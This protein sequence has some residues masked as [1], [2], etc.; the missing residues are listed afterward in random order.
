MASLVYTSGVAEF[1]R[2]NHDWL[3]GNAVAILVTSGYT[4]D[5]DHDFISDLT[6]GSNELSGTGY[7]RKVLGTKTVTNDDTNDRAALDAADVTWTGINTAGDAAAVVIAID[8]GNDATSPLLAYID[9]GGF[10]IVT[11]GGDVTIQWDSN[12]IYAL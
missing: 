5:I 7:S 8:T 6:P 1:A 9:T 12:G 10:P 11:N 4:A 3:T 2:G